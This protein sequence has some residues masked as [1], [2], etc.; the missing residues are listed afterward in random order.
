MK[1]L[2]V[3][4][5]NKI[6]L[7]AELR[8]MTGVQ[9]GQRLVAVPSGRSIV[10]TPLESVDALRGIARGAPVAPAQARCRYRP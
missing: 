2:R 1:P 5:D 9:A 3:T 6:T 10:L 7:P 4:Q 8:A